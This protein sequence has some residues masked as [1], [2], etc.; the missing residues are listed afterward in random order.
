MVTLL[1]YQNLQFKMMP[2]DRDRVAPL[3][4]DWSYCSLVLWCIE[5][6]KINYHLIIPIEVKE[7]FPV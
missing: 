1:L 7:L 2:W 4:M 3:L 6:K 5:E